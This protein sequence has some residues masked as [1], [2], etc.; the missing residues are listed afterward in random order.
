MD[1]FNP[2]DFVRLLVALAAFASVISITLPFF[3]SDQLDDRMKAVALERERLRLGQRQ[4]LMPNKGPKNFTDF[5]KNIAKSLDLIKW[6]GESEMRTN[7]ALAGFRSSGAEM[8]YAFFHLAVPIGMFVFS[9]FYIF[10]LIDFD[11]TT[12]N[13]FFMVLVVTIVSYKLPKIYLSNL[14]T[15][16]Q[17]LL[18]R[19]A[20][21][22]ID[23]LLIAIE[24]GSSIEV[25][26]QRV[27]MEVGAQCIPLAEEIAVLLA[28]LS[29]LPDR[30][31]AYEN[32][33]KRTQIDSIKQLVMVLSQAEKY[34]TSLA[35][36]LRVVADE[37]RQTRMAEAEKKAAALPPKLTVPMILF[38]LPV[39]F[40]IIITPAAIQIS[41]MS[42]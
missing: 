2:H 7:L 9:G 24:S 36:A 12:L 40:I 34:G 21:D 32:F 20:P 35:N 27:G 1:I 5:A 8:V 13:K 39:I 29:Y 38:F 10:V 33:N 42:H 19:G 4:R 23:L 15:K 41:A 6:L 30:R 18:K 3:S 26:F 17:L 31:I 16:R 14:I 11:Q 37:G 25:A 28:E 22:M